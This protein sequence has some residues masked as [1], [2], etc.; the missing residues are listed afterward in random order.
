MLHVEVAGEAGVVSFGHATGDLDV[1]GVSYG[2][3]LDARLIHV[4]AGVDDTDAVNV[5]QLKAVSAVAEY[6]G[7]GWDIGNSSGRV[8][9]VAPG[10]QVDFVAGNTNTRVDVA[11]NTATGNSTVTVA[12]APAAL[13]YTA[14]KAAAG[15]AAANPAAS[16]DAVAKPAAKKAVA[17]AKAAGT[18]AS[19]KA[20]ATASRTTAKAATAKPAATKAA[21]PKAA[22][23]KAAA[24]KK[25]ATRTG[26]SKAA[27]P[28]AAAPKA[29]PAAKT[30]LNPQAAWPFPSGRKP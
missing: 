22:A 30:Q 4:A 21:A 24:A 11:Q 5:A 6:A 19:T 14:T 18:A 29:A 10:K 3:D 8:G 2:S 15:K 28:K 23:P 13:Q 1:F 25:P 16:A 12:A 27:T 9:N 20:S 26:A 7:Q 17:P